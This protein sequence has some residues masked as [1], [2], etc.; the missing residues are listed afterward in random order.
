[1]KVENLDSFEREELLRWFFHWL[2]MDRRHE[3]MQRY[4]QHYNKLLGDA[5]EK[6]PLLRVVKREG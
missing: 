4:P 2:P 1:M 3:M 6:G 5:A